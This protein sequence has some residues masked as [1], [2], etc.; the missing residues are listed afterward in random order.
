MTRLAAT[1]ALVVCAAPLGAQTAEPQFSFT[2]A[3]AYYGVLCD[4]DPDDFVFLTRVPL[5][6]HADPDPSSPVVRTVA[7]N[8]LIE[9]NDWDLVVTVVTDPHTGTLRAPVR[10]DGAVPTTDPRRADWNDAP[11]IG[12]LTV[13]AGTRVEV[14]SDD[15]GDGYANYGGR[16]Y[17]GAFAWTDKLEIT[18]GTG[19][20]AQ[21]YRLVARGDAPAAWVEIRAQD[22]AQVE[23]LCETHS[24]CVPG[25][26]PTY[27]PNRP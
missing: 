23:M 12:A 6:G 21:W 22:R 14:Y 5:S 20:E 17:Y 13:P 16:T 18:Q 25:F 4:C 26:T 27:R 1:L 24:G 9:G 15:G 8:R 3:F 7:A 19:A 11:R 10:L 2:G